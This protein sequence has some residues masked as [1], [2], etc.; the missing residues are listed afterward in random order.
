MPRS[1]TAPTDLP[2]PV[3]QF[4]T[5]ASHAIPVAG[6]LASDPAL[7]EAQL[8]RAEWEQRLADYLATPTS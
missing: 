6:L 8:P 7:R 3:G 2:I 1:E 4:I 5:D